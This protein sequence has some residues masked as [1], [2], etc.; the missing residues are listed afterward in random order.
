MEE[1]KRLLYTD[2]AV[3]DIAIRV[4]ID[5]YFYFSTVFKK[6][7]GMTPMDYRKENLNFDFT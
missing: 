5:N 7:T 4:G 1:A 3:S 6:Y 2:A